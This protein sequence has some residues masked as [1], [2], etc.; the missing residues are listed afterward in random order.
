MKP[1]KSFLGHSH[2]C[3]RSCGSIMVWG[4]IIRNGV[5]H[6]VK[7]DVIMRK[8]QYFTILRRNLPGVIE[9]TSLSSETVVFA[10]DNDPKHAAKIAD[11]DFKVATTVTKY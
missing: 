11:L 4:C 2:V 8:E 3:D 5:R 1:N 10:E 7:I 6:L 9:K